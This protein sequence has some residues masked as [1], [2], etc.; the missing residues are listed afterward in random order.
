MTDTAA[1]TA[2]PINRVECFRLR[3]AAV[4]GMGCMCLTNIVPIH[5]SPTRESLGL[6]AKSVNHQLI[7]QQPLISP[8]GAI[9]TRQ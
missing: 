1:N 7:A 2:N 5:R 8:N 6:Q 3:M 9:E 4:V